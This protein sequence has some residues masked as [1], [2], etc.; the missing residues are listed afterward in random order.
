MTKI[1]NIVLNGVRYDLGSDESMEMVARIISKAIY[2]S[3]MSEAIAELKEA[4]GMTVYTITYNLGGVSIDN[5]ISN[6]DELQPFTAT[7]TKDDAEYVY[8]T[9][10]ITMGETDITSS[11]WNSSTGEINIPSVTGDVAITVITV[12]E[13]GW[14]D[15]VAYDQ[16]EY[17]MI[18]GKYLDYNTGNLSS[19]SGYNCSQ[20]LPCHEANAVYCDGG[21]FRYWCIYDENES[22][23]AGGMHRDGAKSW[24]PIGASV[25]Y[26]QLCS[27]NDELPNT[28]NFVPHK[29]EVIGENTIPTLGKL[30]AVQNPES[31]YMRCYGMEV[32]K[33]LNSG[34][35]GVV[36]YDSNK[37]ETSRISVTNDLAS[38]TIP[39]GAIY[40]RWT[41]GYDNGSNICWFEEAS[42]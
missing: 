34:R 36:F 40:F 14:T 2:K 35:R 13:Y 30:Y 28:T 42:E 19:S 8:K 33:I 18:T 11:A 5:R 17:P 16:T 22:R 27:G 23:L 12:N 9:V 7:I 29:L 26:V 39:E 24:I 32:L 20:L 3:D 6:I 4:I 25:Y 37:N 15:G 41:A 38:A 21:A 31:T 1:N 10:T